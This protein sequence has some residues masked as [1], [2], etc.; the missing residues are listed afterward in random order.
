MHDNVYI[1]TV[2]KHSAMSRDRELA[3]M[4]PPINTIPRTMVLSR[5]EDGAVVGFACS[6][7]AIRK[8]KWYTN[9]LQ[10]GYREIP[11]FFEKT[12]EKEA[13]IAVRGDVE[14]CEEGPVDVEPGSYML[15]LNYLQPA[16][17]RRKIIDNAILQTL[18]EM[19][20]TVLEF[21]PSP[22]MRSGWAKIFYEAS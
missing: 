1:C 10:P 16:Y 18:S 11:S 3:F 2:R 20:V 4:Y 19:P 9:R 13:W 21:C 5:A 22:N 12:E 8:G 17:R 7:E 14:G 6:V 15:K